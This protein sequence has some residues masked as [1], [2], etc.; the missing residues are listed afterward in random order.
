LITL[1]IDARHARRATNLDDGETGRRLPGN[2]SRKDQLLLRDRSGT[3][4]L[5]SANFGDRPDEG[6]PG[7][8]FSFHNVSQPASQ[9]PGAI[10]KNLAAKLVSCG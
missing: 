4:S 3:Q 8:I 5:R 9:H 6:L 2:Q 10:R 1:I 7:S